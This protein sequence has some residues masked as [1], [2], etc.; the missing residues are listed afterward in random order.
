MHPP[1]GKPLCRC[2]FFQPR[3]PLGIAARRQP[4]MIGVIFSG[5][6]DIVQ[7][8]AGI[9][10]RKRTI[11]WRPYRLP[12]VDRRANQRRACDPGYPGHPRPEN[13]A[14]KIFPEHPSARISRRKP[15]GPAMH[16]FATTAHRA[17]SHSGSSAFCQ[18]PFRFPTGMRNNLLPRLKEKQSFLRFFH[19]R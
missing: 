19:S 12:G 15:D 4:Y 11:R 8:M 18:L 7:T 13:R 5:C 2:A 9:G 14:L 1:Q 3:S 17:C 10:G 6:L 16:E